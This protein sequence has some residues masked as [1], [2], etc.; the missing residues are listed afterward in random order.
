[1]SQNARLL[2]SLI[3]QEIQTTYGT[4]ALLKQREGQKGVW[5]LDAPEINYPALLIECGYITDKKDLAFITDEG[6][7]EKIAKDILRAIERFAKTKEGV[8]EAMVEP[9]ILEKGAI[10]KNGLIVMEKTLVEAD[11]KTNTDTLPANIKSVDITTDN[12]V[13]VIYKDDKAEKIT[14][15]EAQ[16]RGIAPVAKTGIEIRSGKPGVL[17]SVLYI[18]DGIEISAADIKSI[19]PG[20]I[21]TINVIKDKSATDKYGA[22]AKNGVVEITLKKGVVVGVAKPDN[23]LKVIGKPAFPDSVLCF[24]DGVEISTAEME[25][26]V[27]EKIESMTVLKDKSATDKYGARGKNGVIEITLK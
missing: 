20:D 1:Y 5:V 19:N 25:K 11:K 14:M 21:E 9:S 27:P 13:I 7:Q 4:G 23:V 15:A 24:L 8:K 2:G 3:S 22:R 26:L 6:N 10:S 18:L 12:K 17:D 16:K